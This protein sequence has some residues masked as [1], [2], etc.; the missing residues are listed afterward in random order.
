L[1]TDQSKTKNTTEDKSEETKN[2]KTDDASDIKDESVITEDT[3]DNTVTTKVVSSYEEKAGQKQSVKNS[4]NVVGASQTSLRTVSNLNSVGS[5]VAIQT[6]I[7]NSST[8]QGSI[9][10]SNIATVVNGL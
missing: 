2:E 8:I 10:Q 7:A 9:I 6:N 3:L 4:L 1:K 5:A